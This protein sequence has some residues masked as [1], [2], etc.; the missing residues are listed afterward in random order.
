MLLNYQLSLFG[1]EGRQPGTVHV[2]KG[3][4]CGRAGPVHRVSP[5]V[6]LPLADAA[7]MKIWFFSV[8][9]RIICLLPIEYVDCE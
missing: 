8:Y 9:D 2:G 3:T 4:P 7:D 5:G 6:K 1:Y